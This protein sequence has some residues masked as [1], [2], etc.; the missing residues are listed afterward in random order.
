MLAELKSLGLVSQFGRVQDFQAALNPAVA[1]EY[2]LALQ[3][4][5]RWCLQA[6]WFGQELANVAE[7]ERIFQE[8]LAKAV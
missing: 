5:Q 3:R 4:L 1:D 2:Q 8:L 6:N 7:F